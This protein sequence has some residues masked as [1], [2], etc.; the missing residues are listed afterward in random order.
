MLFRVQQIGKSFEFKMEDFEMVD[1]STFWC[2]GVDAQVQFTQEYPSTSFAG[3]HDAG[4]PV[5]IV[6]N[7]EGTT[8]RQNGNGH[9]GLTSNWF[10][11]SI[12]S[13]TQLVDRGVKV[14][15]ASLRCDL[16]GQATIVAVHVYMGGGSRKQRLYAGD[17]LSLSARCV[18]ESFPID[19]VICTE[20]LVMCVKV[21]FEDGGE[22][23]F[24]GAGAQFIGPE[25]HG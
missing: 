15:H 14:D 6:R 2:H 22:I 13:A 20:P 17:D 7:S 9:G 23:T 3:E 8:I 16:N 24:A 21:L 18:E 10:H 1:R 19:D 5:A 11:F 12:P 25:E 4:T